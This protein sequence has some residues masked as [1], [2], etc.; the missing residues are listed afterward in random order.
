MVFE[1]EKI[2]KAIEQAIKNAKKRNFDEA[3]DIAINLRDVDLRKPEN[4]IKTEIVL[5][6]GL[7]KELSIGVIA[8]GELAVKSKQKANIVLSK[9][10]LEELGKDKKKA[11]KIAEEND[12]FIA[13]ADLMP[14]VGKT[15]GAILGIRGKMPKPIPPQADPI[16][17]MERLSRTIR[18][19]TRDKPV[20]HAKAGLV[21]MPLEQLVDNV[22]TILKAVES[23]LERGASNIRSVYVKT[24]MGPAVRLC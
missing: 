15:M 5:P 12:V 21:T 17:V 10:Q 7:G 20:I 24:T 16:P 2:R 23:K 19:N 9:E 18:I 3:L 22:E 6:H 4:R 8:E 13:Q 14:L 1:P 11:K